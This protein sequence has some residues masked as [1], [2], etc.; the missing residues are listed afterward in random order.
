MTLK[1]M[2]A[3]RQR[4]VSVLVSFGLT[5]CGLSAP[6][7]ENLGQVVFDDTFKINGPLKGYTTNNPEVVKVSAKDGRYFAPIY[8]NSNEKTLHF[9]QYQGRLDAQLISFPFTL[10]ARNI[11]IGTLENSQ[12]MPAIDGAPYIFAGVQVHTKALE[13]R[14]SAHVVVGHRGQT[15]NTVEGKHTVNGKSWVTDVGVNKALHGRADLMIQGLP[16]KTLRVFWQPA[17]TDSGPRTKDRWIAYAG[18]GKL[19]GESP[20]FTE[21]VYV[22][23]IT[24]AFQDQGLPFVGTA[25]QFQIF[26]PTQE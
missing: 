22:G 21:E 14:N 23:L 25:D 3:I 11:G 15:Y 8:D 6:A 5:A 17:T 9:N 26:K 12:E 16:D 10:I 13:E 24:Y 4:C 18:H 1:K 20:V 19:P 7:Q 2:K